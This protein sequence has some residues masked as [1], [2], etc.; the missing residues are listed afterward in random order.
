MKEKLNLL[1][2]FSR[3]KEI[4]SC[5]ISLHLYA[6]RLVQGLNMGNVFHPI[7]LVTKGAED[8]IDSLAGYKVDKI[9]INGNEKVTFSIKLDRLLGIVPFEKQLQELDVPAGFWQRHDRFFAGT[10][11][12]KQCGDGDEQSGRYGKEQRNRSDGSYAGT[13][14]RQL[15]SR[16]R[17][18]RST[19]RRCT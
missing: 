10:G 9:V 8:Y 17:Q 4:P 3:I 15:S 6:G 7:A 16:L 11:Y 18:H 19:V 1:I 12:P 2:D 13:E 14:H 5:A